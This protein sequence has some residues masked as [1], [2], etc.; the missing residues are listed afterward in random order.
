M[1][2]NQDDKWHSLLALSAPTFNAES[3]PPYGFM[4]AMLAQLR[5]ERQQEQQLGRL[6]W[7]AIFA[8]LAVLAL[9]AGVTLGVRLQL[10][11]GDDLEPGMRGLI[12]VENVPAS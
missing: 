9:S 4:T 2:T 11:R 1:N 6:C 10:N 8:S 3:A 5:L 7:R 12:Q